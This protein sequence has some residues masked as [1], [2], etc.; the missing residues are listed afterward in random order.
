M[1][2]T[3][4]PDEEETFL[5]FFT[6]LLVLRAA[7]K[8]SDTYLLAPSQA[9]TNF[10]MTPLTST[11]VH[12][13]WQLPPP[14]T[15]YGMIIGFKLLYRNISSSGEQLTVITFGNNSTLARNVTGLGKYTEYEFQVSAFSSVGNGPSS[16]KV[17]RTHQDGE[18]EVIVIL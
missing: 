16:T 15:I 4:Y 2:Y 10:T 1:A 17:V 6:I 11:G 14:H 18:T 5:F 12:A 8:V 7:V 13:S 3:H 9:P